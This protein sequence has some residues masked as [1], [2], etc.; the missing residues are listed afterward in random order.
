MRRTCRIN[1]I[2]LARANLAHAMTCLP[3]TTGAIENPQQQSFSA[4]PAFTLSSSQAFLAF[5]SRLHEK[6]MKRFS[7]TRLA[8]LRIRDMDS[9][10]STKEYAQ[11]KIFPI[12]TSFHFGPMVSVVLYCL[13]ALIVGLL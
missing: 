9:I 1:R 2:N 4:L 3:E 8:Y 11:G 10:W 12:C 7:H 6:R 5:G 13:W